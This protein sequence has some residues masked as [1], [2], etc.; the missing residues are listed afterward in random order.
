MLDGINW[1]TDVLPIITSQM[2]SSIISGAIATIAA[3]AV[4]GYGAR[5]LIG[6]F[7]KRD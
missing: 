4:V 1:A 6:V 7:Y 3:I 5:A 2:S